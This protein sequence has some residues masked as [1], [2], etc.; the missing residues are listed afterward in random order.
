MFGEAPKRLLNELWRAIRIVCNCTILEALQ[1]SA[2]PP[3][4]AFLD[5]PRSGRAI[6][7]RRCQTSYREIQTFCAIAHYQEVF[8]S[9]KLFRPRFIF[10][11]PSLGLVWYL[12]I[13]LGLGLVI[14]LVISLVIGLVIGL[15]MDLVIG[16]VIGLVISLVMD[17]VIGLGLVI[18]LVMDLVISLVIS[19]VM[20]SV[21][22][23]VYT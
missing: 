19:L 9:A 16:L 12:V 21:I 11:K 4:R 5:N 8:K 18:S 3:I 22:Y 15:V 2:I 10:I 23:L 20:V 17:L 13:G 7:W 1:T 6:V 14:S